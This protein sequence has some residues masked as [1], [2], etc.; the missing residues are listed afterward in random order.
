MSTATDSASDA[1]MLELVTA[2]GETVGSALTRAPAPD[3]AEVHETAL[4]DAA[5]LAALR[6]RAP[7]SAWFPAVLA[8]ALPEIRRTVPGGGW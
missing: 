6:S 8:A 3:P 5:A 4:V 1:I 7:F 2:D